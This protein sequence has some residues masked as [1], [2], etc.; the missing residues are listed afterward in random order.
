MKSG[1]SKT[2]GHA[3]GLSSSMLYYQLLIIGLSLLILGEKKPDNIVKKYVTPDQINYAQQISN[4]FSYDRALIW[5]LNREQ[6]ITNCH[7][8]HDFISFFSENFSAFIHV[9]LLSKC[10][11]N[12][13]LRGLPPETFNKRPEIS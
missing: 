4:S 2:L 7:R 10:V 1:I 9:Y 6:V 11:E 13:Q 12:C 8:K 3:L 5:I